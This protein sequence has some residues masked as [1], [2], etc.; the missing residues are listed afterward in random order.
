MAVWISFTICLEM[1]NSQMRR[2]VAQM[3][4]IKNLF[5]LVRSAAVLLLWILLFTF[6]LARL[7][8]KSHT[9][10]KQT[11]LS[12]ISA[13]G[14]QAFLEEYVGDSV[15]SVEHW[16]TAKS[17]YQSLDNATHKLI[18][19]SCDSEVDTTFTVV[20]SQRENGYILMIQNGEITYD[21]IAAF[22][23]QHES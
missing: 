18:D 12:H 22:I 8:V 23:E 15:S 11:A 3:A 6:F 20:N 5:Q 7:T 13:D 2:T 19:T 4:V 1:Q 17:T 9:T 10:R 16:E 14:I 21:L